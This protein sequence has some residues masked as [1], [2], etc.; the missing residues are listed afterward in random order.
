M[1][2]LQ[3]KDLAKKTGVASSAIRYYE[4][5]E[6]L[7]PA[8]RG[9]NGY[10]VYT[11]KDVERLRFIQRAKSLDFSLNEIKEILH[12]RE[13]GETP[14]AYVIS[15]IYIKVVEVERKITQL[16][17]LKSELNILQAE[18]SQLPVEKI[19]AKQCVCHII[20]NEHLTNLSE[21]TSN[22]V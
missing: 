20:E 12:L 17:Q 5:I 21:L 8:N 3:I 14:C 6:L 19:E 16:N 1:E 18:I 15:Q 10:R 11:T 22:F 4:E 7:P 9:D 2:D 13:R